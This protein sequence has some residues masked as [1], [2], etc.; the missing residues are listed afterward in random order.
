MPP[1]L[2]LPGRAVSAVAAPRYGRRRERGL[3]VAIG[4]LLT[5]LRYPTTR[6]GKII[7][8]MLAVLIF[9]FLSL[10]LVSGLL[11][12]RALLP[13]RAGE[14]IDPTSFLG[15][16]EILPFET[17]DGETHSGWFFP[18]LRGAPV[19]V[20]CHGYR[21]SRTEILTLAT[22]LQQHRYNVF[23]FN[24]AGHGESPV[25]YTTLGF[26]ETNEL[27]AA[28][29]MLATR[30]DIDTQRMGVWGYSMGA[31]AALS[32]AQ[33]FPRVK[34]VALDSIYPHP[35]DLLRRELTRGGGGSIPLA[36]ALATLEFRVFNLFT[37]SGP[38]PVAALPQ[39]VGLPK[40]FILGDDTPQLADFT[41]ELYQ[42]AP[43]PKELVQLPRT[44]MASLVE[45]ERRN[46]ENLV[47]SFFL[48]NLPLVS[49]T[50]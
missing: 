30:T 2:C 36:P 22:S 41:R 48:R 16:V 35:A 20:I 46:Y 32:A 21:T 23:S 6:R 25:G 12:S 49:S 24:F 34:A 3:F 9:S 13:L 40:L 4:N 39:T 37:G 29:E 31:Y 47:V 18:G 11:L 19:V 10:A 42:Q 45:D 50:P 44:N 17:P 7:V 15:N 8:G 14:T 28:L 1:I 43:G 33:Q 38:D 27:L 5:E 26:K